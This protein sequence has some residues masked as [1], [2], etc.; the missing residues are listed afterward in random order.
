MRSLLAAAMVLTD[1]NFASIVSAIEEG[2]AVYSNIRKFVTY[3][4][5]SNVPEAVPF[6]AYMLFDVPLPLTVMQILAVDLGTDLIPKVERL[7]LILVNG[8]LQR[9]QGTRGLESHRHLL[10]A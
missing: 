8:L 5:A 7:A 10:P 9:Y 4:F 6:V 2:R 1:D 3:I